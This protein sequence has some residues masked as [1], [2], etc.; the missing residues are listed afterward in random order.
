MPYADYYKA[1]HLFRYPH[2][3]SEVA[4]QHNTAVMVGVTGLLPMTLFSDE[5]F[6]TYWTR[7]EFAYD[8]AAFLKSV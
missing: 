2:P 8:F 6:R 4:V 7:D 5:G 3:T 1:N